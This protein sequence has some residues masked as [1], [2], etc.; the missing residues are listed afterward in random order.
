MA[1]E[2]VVRFVLL[3]EDWE[4]RKGSANRINVLGLLSN[5]DVYDEPPLPVY[6]AELC[7]IVGLT[8]WRGKGAVSLQCLFEET[9]QVTFRTNPRTVA[10]ENDPLRVVIIPFRIRDCFFPNVGVYSIQFLYAGK[11]LGE[12]PL[13]VR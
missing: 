13:R 8:E 3:A 11:V 1:L 6:V 5:L 9:G 2:P 4:R 10:M 12:C 7:C